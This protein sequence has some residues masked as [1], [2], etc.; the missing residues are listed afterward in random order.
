M[1]KNYL[2]LLLGFGLVFNSAIAQKSNPNDKLSV[3]GMR[4]MHAVQE[5]K[6]VPNDKSSISEKE[7]FRYA[8]QDIEGDYF[9]GALLKV[10]QYADM[11]AF[12]KLGVAVNTQAGNIWSVKIPIDKLDEVAALASVEY[13]DISTPITPKLEASR[14]ASRVDLVHTGAGTLNKAN[15]GEGVVVG[16]I[17]AGFDYTH[18]MFYDTSGTEYRIKAIWHGRGNGGAPSGYSYGHQYYT[19]SSIKAQQYDVTDDSHGTH[20]AGVAVGAGGLNIGTPTFSDRYEYLGM[21]PMSDIIMISYRMDAGNAAFSDVILNGI[22][23]IFDW[24]TNEGKPAVVNMSLGTHLGPHDGSSL[25]DQGLNN[26]VGRG[27]IV[28]GAAGNEGEKKMYMQHNLDATGEIITIVGESPQDENLVELWGDVNKDFGVNIMLFD[29]VNFV[30]SD[31]T[32]YQYA[33]Q[34][35][36]FTK[37]IVDAVNDTLGV[38]ITTKFSE[39]NNKTHINVGYANN[40]DHVLVMKVKGAGNVHMWNYA[41]N[42]GADFYNNG[43]SGVEEG[44]NASS[45]GEIGGTADSIIT[46]GAYTSK[47]NFTDILTSS[48]Q[49]AS[50][51]QPIGT[52]AEFSSRGPTA[53]GRMKPEVTAPG[54]VIISSVNKF[55]PTYD[56]YNPHSVDAI[57]DG[58]DTSYFAAQQGT[59]QAS[60]AVA[61]IVALW[62]ENDP[63][64]SV[65]DVKRILATSSVKDGFTGPSNSNTWGNG[66]IDAY[67]GLLVVSL[68]ELEGFNDAFD[69]FPNPTQNLLNLKAK[70]KQINRLE[71]SSLDGKIILERRV[72]K[73]AITLDVSDLSSGMYLIRVYQ[74]DKIRTGKIMIH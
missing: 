43:Y 49:R 68:D 46:V 39:F 29:T 45:M 71:I 69:L 64:L 72:N 14:S 3:T 10:N 38:Q 26:L 19:E 59:S 44:S 24:A 4:F 48:T 1:K 18:P 47:N 31:S 73:R 54:N 23:Y 66:K 53:D 5:Q 30:F 42:N 35:N 62:L 67:A 32:G 65:F 50:F 61:G 51:D 15:L 20:V 8:I 17:D 37:E 63:N 13:I 16:I 58:S 36:V 33:S 21:A 56:L 57:L 41:D 70:E 2:P 60:P 25:F 28:V 40:S 52:I 11:E 74:E 55:E 7:K 34:N 12:N 27:K 6:L 22:N 9:F